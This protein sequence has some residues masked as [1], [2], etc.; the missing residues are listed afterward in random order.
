MSRAV[1]L[2]RGAATQSSQV[3]SA[4]EVARPTMSGTGGALQLGSPR[5]QTVE[6]EVETINGVARLHN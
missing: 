6:K 2:I 3:A 1:R 5:T 4:G